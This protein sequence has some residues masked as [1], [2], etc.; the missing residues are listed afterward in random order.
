MSYVS[1]ISATVLELLCS[2]LI[3]NGLM[4]E[5]TKI[6]IFVAGIFILSATLYIT[7]LPE[8]WCC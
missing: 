8:E 4:G 1:V 6:R 2:V 3:I 5:E 7:V